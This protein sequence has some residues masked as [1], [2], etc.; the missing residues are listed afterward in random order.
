MVSTKKYNEKIKY[1]SNNN[2]VIE[3]Q[4]IIPIKKKNN[5]TFIINI[6]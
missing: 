2:Q 3:I 1:I 6:K 5:Y 4:L